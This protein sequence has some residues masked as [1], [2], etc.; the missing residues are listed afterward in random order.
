[1]GQRYPTPMELLSDTDWKVRQS[2]WLLIPF[3]GICCV[4]WLGWM[5][6]A[7]RTG[8]RRYWAYMAVY[9]LLGPPLAIAA[10]EVPEPWED[11]LIWTYL[12]FAGICLLHAVAENPSILKCLAHNR[13]W[14]IYGQRQVGA[15]YG[16]AHGAQGP[17]GKSAYPGQPNIPGQP[18]PTDFLGL[19]QDQQ[20][21]WRSP[22]GHSQAPPQPPRQPPAQPQ[23]W[24]GLPLDEQPT[25]VPGST[26][27]G[28]HQAAP[29]PT[30]QAAGSVVKVD[31]N[32]ATTAELVKL[33]GIDAA[34]ADA[35]VAGR[36]ARPYADP[37]DVVARSGLQPHQWVRI[38]DLVTVAPPTIIPPLQE[39]PTHGRMLDL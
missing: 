1:M 31:L 23:P 13:P 15:V 28:T 37:D 27:A 36:R 12:G 7:I 30:P 5:V 29:Q 34:A 33:P 19:Q 17:Y 22:Q 4:G 38:R 11:V 24:A 35:I 39:P 16:G 2:L 25:R 9:A 18:A 32:K 21:Y 6:V 10:T 14:M 3:L 8:R 20:A 26:P